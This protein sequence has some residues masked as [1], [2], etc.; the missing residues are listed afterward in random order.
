MPL[1]REAY[2]RLVGNDEIEWVNRAHFFH[3]AAEAMRRILI[4]HARV[5]ARLQRGGGR[6]RVPLDVVDLATQ[7]D[8]DQIMTLEEASSRLEKEDADAARVVRLR[9]YVGLSVEGTAKAIGAS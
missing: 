2:L 9:F 6:A 7:A 1:V 5:K 4:E 3:A 8:A